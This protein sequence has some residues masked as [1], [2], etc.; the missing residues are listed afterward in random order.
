MREI[1]KDCKGAIPVI[2]IIALLIWTA[3]CI[4]FG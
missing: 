2:V 4:Y 3:L 1:I